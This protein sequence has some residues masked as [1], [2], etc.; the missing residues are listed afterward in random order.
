MVRQLSSQF[1]KLAFLTALVAIGWAVSLNTVRA[2]EPEPQASF[3]VNMGNG[4]LI[5]D[6]AE[7]VVMAFQG[8]RPQDCG[9]LR[10]RSGMMVTVTIIGQYEDKPLARFDFH[11]MPPWGVQTQYGWWAGEI[12]AEVEPTALGVDA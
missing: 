11:E 5:C 2:E 10:T 12:P 4:A 6:N 3:D 9:F 8:F 7:S 1:G